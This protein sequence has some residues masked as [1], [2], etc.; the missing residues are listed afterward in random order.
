MVHAAWMLAVQQADRGID[1]VIDLVV[2]VTGA[3]GFL[4]RRVV[5]EL[6][7]RRQQVRCLVH[8]PGRERMFSHRAVEVQYGSVR[9]P[10]ALSNAF[11][12]VEAVVQLVGI[13]RRKRP[14]SFAGIHR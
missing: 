11:Y 4:G 7:E 14:D 6:L 2:L 9:D 10:A 12:D 13:I 8:T 1:G 3:T 5:R